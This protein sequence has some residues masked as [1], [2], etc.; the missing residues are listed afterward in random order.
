ME[1][2][3]TYDI[4]VGGTGLSP[5]AISPDWMRNNAAAIRNVNRTMPA[6][7]AGYGQAKEDYYQKEQDFFASVRSI[8]RSSIMRKKAMSRLMSVSGAFLDAQC[9]KVDAARYAQIK[10][11]AKLA[12][13]QDYQ[14]DNAILATNYPEGIIR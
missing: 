4:S 2:E 9:A 8:T 6:I 1:P 3:E 11:V 7:S 5:T 13:L 10:G 14:V 12:G